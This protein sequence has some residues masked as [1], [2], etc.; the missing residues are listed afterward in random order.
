MT[1]LQ[2]YVKRISKES[3][4]HLNQIRSDCW[5][6]NNLLLPHVCLYSSFYAEYQ[7]SFQCV[8]AFRTLVRAGIPNRWKQ[9]YV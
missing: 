7:L 8:W 6:V 1:P 3:L 9:P 5:H 4:Q 2:N